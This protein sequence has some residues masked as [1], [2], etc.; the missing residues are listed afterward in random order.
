MAAGGGQASRGFDSGLMAG[1]VVAS[2]KHG[3]NQL[4]CVALTSGWGSDGTGEVTKRSEAQGTGEASVVCRFLLTGE[5]FVW[6][7]RGRGSCCCV[8]WNRAL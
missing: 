7:F 1:P 6:T 4:V 2:A 3:W 8:F 5:C